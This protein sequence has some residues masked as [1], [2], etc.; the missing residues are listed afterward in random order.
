MFLSFGDGSHKFYMTMPNVLHDDHLIYLTLVTRLF[1][2]ILQ[3]M[4]TISSEIMML[5][6]HLKFDNLGVQNHGQWLNLTNRYI[7]ILITR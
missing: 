2:S 4:D 7:F 3:G 6:E 1:A 5:S